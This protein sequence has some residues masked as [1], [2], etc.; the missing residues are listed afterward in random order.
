MDKTHSMTEVLQ[1]AVG[2]IKNTRGEILISLRDS[3]SHQGGLWEFPGG[4]IEPGESVEQALVRE[5]HEELGITV[6]AT[7]PLI[8]IR[9]DYPDLSVC[10][11]VLSVE[12][13]SGR[14][15]SCEGQPIRWVGGAS[16]KKFSFPAANRPIISAALLPPY[17]AILDDRD[18]KA[19]Q[20]N[21]KHILAQGIKLVQ[22]RLKNT[23]SAKAAEF[24]EL[25][26]RQCRAAGAELL[27]NS[28]VAG[29]QT[30][31]ADGLHLTS[32]DLSMLTE[33]PKVAGWLAASCHNI[34]ELHKA[35]RLGLD[36][37]VLA[38]VLPTTTH[39]GAKTLGWAQ[40]SELAAQAGMPV[41]AMGGLAK[42]DLDKVQRAGGHGVSGI[43]AFLV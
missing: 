43:R 30:L 4:K 38:P 19:L 28:S 2:V 42:D 27:I 24:I 40:F 9:H 22:A 11:K 23:P 7:S 25:A 29:A 35:R 17:Y 12:R 34:E 37:V 21:L 5:L 15:Q 39:P 13:F 18:D 26:R 6:E 8:A 33:R 36:F 32:R 14:A 31:A 16:L 20:A 1:V 10:L 41:Y 3:S